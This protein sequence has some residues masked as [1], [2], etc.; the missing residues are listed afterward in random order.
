[1]EA[2]QASNQS[3]QAGGQKQESLVQD[4]PGVIN[5]ALHPELISD[6]VAYSMLF[7]MIANR[8]EESAKKSIRAYVRQIFKCDECAKKGSFGQGKGLVDNPDIDALLAVAEEHNQ[9]VSVLDKQAETIKGRS[10]PDPAPEVM[11]KLTD[12]QSQNEAVGA[13]LAASLPNRLSPQGMEKLRQ[14]IVERVKPGIKI[15]P[16]PQPPPGSDYYQEPPPAGAAPPQKM[17]VH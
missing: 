14:Y 8:E 4:P 1:V 6:Q 9:R 13:E 10:W 17:H 3:P 7:R 12:L 15:V 16:G 2:V 5:G 11:A